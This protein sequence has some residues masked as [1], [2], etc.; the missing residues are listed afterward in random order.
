MRTPLNK[1]TLGVHIS[2]ENKVNLNEFKLGLFVIENTKKNA[3]ITDIISIIKCKD[4]FEVN[5]NN[6]VNGEKELVAYDFCIDEDFFIFKPEVKEGDVINIRTI[7]NLKLPTYDLGEEAP[8]NI[9]D[10]LELRRD[11][12]HYTTPFPSFINL[13]F[14]SIL[15]ELDPL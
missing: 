12:T 6:P 4:I 13:F 7:V 5:Y 3:S 11:I 14:V 2:L 10:F 9:D 8:Y 15:I 1:T